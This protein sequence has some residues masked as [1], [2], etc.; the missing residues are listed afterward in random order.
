[1]FLE[2][3]CTQQTRWP[4]HTAHSSQLGLPL[5][6]SR[7]RGFKEG[8]LENVWHTLNTV[9]VWGMFWHTQPKALSNFLAQK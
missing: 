2:L 9:Q 6:E 1:M 7:H 4:S 3:V 5:H 8:A